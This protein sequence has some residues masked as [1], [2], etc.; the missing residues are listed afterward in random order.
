MLQNLKRRTSKEM[1]YQLSLL[2]ERIKD[3]VFDRVCK[4][5]D[6]NMLKKAAMFQSKDQTWN[7]PLYLYELIKKERNINNYDTDPATNE[8]NPLGCKYFFTK[9]DDG[10]KQSWKGS[11]FINPPFTAKYNGKLRNLTS[12]FIKEAWLRTQTEKNPEVSMV[13]MLI[14][15]RTDTIAFHR[16]IWKQPN[17]KLDFVKGRVKFGTSK[18]GAPFGSMIVD[19]YRPK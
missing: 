19:W 8:N 11:V 7:T 12:L 18:I 4:F 6:P 14:P 5:K 2:G 9:E 16:Y 3:T 13:T 17:V 1:S 10:L 15:A